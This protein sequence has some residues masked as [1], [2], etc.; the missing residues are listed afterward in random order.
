MAVETRTR[1]IKVKGKKPFK[2]DKVFKPYLTLKQKECLLSSIKPLN[3][4]CANREQ[5]V[6]YLYLLEQK[7]NALK[8]CTRQGQNFDQFEINFSSEFVYK[9][10]L[11]LYFALEDYLHVKDTL[12]YVQY[13]QEGNRNLICD[14]CKAKQIVASPCFC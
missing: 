9:A 3:V 12:L 5:V 8:K 2:T 4:R 1:T 13:T 7:I 14:F 6:G 11:D 10:L